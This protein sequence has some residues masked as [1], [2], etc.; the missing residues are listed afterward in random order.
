MSYLPPCAFSQ[1]ELGSAMSVT[2]A[3]IITTGN[4]VSEC[5]VRVSILP[6]SH[7]MYTMNGSLAKI[8]PFDLILNSASSLRK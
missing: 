7:S 2:G 4:S 6:I 8:V 3:A 5:S 1:A